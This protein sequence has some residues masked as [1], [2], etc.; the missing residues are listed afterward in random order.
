MTKRVPSR[1]ELARELSEERDPTALAR[2]VRH[3]SWLIRWEAIQSLGK[4]DSP[5]AEPILLDLLREPVDRKDLPF[6]NSALGQV[7]SA[8]A[9][10]ALGA[11][12]HDRSED[13]KT[14]AIHALMEVG[15]PSLT[16]LFID[17]LADPFW[18]A[19]AYAMHALDRHGDQRAIAAV[20]KRVRVILSRDRY[21][22]YGG[23][24]E[25]M[26][27]LDY[28]SRWR[29]SSAAAETLAL[30][31]QRWVRLSVPERRWF[32]ATFPDLT[33]PKLRQGLAPGLPLPV[34]LVHEFSERPRPALE[35][36]RSDAGPR[37]RG[38]LSRFLRRR[39]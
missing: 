16:P 36:L 15:D 23:W 30:V 12:I 7:G 28:L 1:Y 6:A 22:N 35:A 31:P 26:F 8:A 17:A 34:E 14:S 27:G 25:L 21:R 4:S 32:T 13:I 33:P 5:E 39:S 2:Y 38:L 37:G 19:K 24:T 11:L 10:P 9:V 3:K 29:E 20:S 18:A